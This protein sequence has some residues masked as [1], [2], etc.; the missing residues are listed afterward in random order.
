MN[1]LI[2]KNLVQRFKQG[3]KIVKAYNGVELNVPS[4]SS[5][6]S[7]SPKISL[8]LNPND[9]IK[10]VTEVRT[11]TSSYLEPET[12]ETKKQREDYFNKKKRELGFNSTPET[13]D[14]RRALE[15]NYY[16]QQG[17]GRLYTENGKNYWIGS[18]GS[19]TFK[20]GKVIGE[21]GKQYWKGSDGSMTLLKSNKSIKNSKTSSFAKAFNEARAKGLKEFS[22]G[23]KKFNTMKAGETKDQWLKNLT[24][25]S[26][27]TVTKTPNE[28]KEEAWQ[29]APQSQARNVYN[30]ALNI[31]AP[32]I[33][34]ALNNKQIAED[35]NVPYEIRAKAAMGVFKNG[36]ILPSRNAITRFKNR[37]SN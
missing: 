21:D 8:G 37:K 29:N 22:F 4:L 7:K 3:R 31:A 18:D 9:I 5:F 17:K 2:S 25:V 13:S 14:Y 1:K 28:I 12:P 35:A 27:P 34:E 33:L 16:S 30:Q 15:N 19:K 10:A 32:K 36:G 6:P 11:P 20:S 26:Q 24:T 23:S